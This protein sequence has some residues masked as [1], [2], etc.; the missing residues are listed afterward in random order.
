MPMTILHS[1]P[2][3]KDKARVF[4]SG[5]NTVMLSRMMAGSSIKER[6]GRIASRTFFLCC[7]SLRILY[8]P[9]FFFPYMIRCILSRYFSYQL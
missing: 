6:L 9:A 1:I 2:A 4:L 8:H 5:H 7:Y 3:G